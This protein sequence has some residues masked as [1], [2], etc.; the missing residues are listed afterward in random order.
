MERLKELL[1]KELYNQISSRI[2]EHNNKDENKEKRIR[3][4]NLESG[5]YV[6][7]GK[8]D[9]ETG[10]LNDLLKGKEAEISKANN[11]ISEMKKDAKGNEDLQGKIKDYET[12]VTNLKAQLQEAKFN[13]ALKVALL[14]EKAVD[15]DYLMFKINEKLKEQG[16]NLELDENENIK[17]IDELILETKA[18]YPTQFE[19]AN[20]GKGIVID[21][22]KLS[23]GKDTD[24]GITKSDLLNKSYAERNRIYNDNPEMYKQIM[25]S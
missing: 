12:A 2:E 14:S 19:T 13:S 22:L 21:P 6:A 24:E 5:E 1:G 25:N 8:Y 18:T 11:L 23:K 16:K 10:R 7:K 3:L 4:A 15:I 17:G 20:V 9:L